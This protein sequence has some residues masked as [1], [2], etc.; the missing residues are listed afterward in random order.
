MFSQEYARTKSVKNHPFF[1]TAVYAPIADNKLIRIAWV[2][3]F[4][5]LPPIFREEFRFTKTSS[6]GYAKLKMVSL[7]NSVTAED[8]WGLSITSATWRTSLWKWLRKYTNKTK[9]SSKESSQRSSLRKYKRQR[10]KWPLMSLIS[11]KNTGNKSV[12]WGKS[13]ST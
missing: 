6:L 11:S 7:T 12:G 13:S 10:T 8:S 9:I 2:R 1:V 5:E 4:T 3:C